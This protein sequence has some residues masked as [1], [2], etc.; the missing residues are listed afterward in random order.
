LAYAITQAV[1][2]GWWVA[3]YPGTLSYDSITY[4]WQVST[5]NWTTQHSV[6][7]NA[8]VWLSLRST[9][10]L[11]VL[12]LA[13]TLAMA[14]A[15][16]YAVVGLRRLGARAGWLILAAGAAVCLP[17]IGTF[18]VYVSKDV[19]FAVTQVFL[20]G[21]VARILAGRPRPSRRLWIALLAEFLAMGLFRQ[22]GFVVIGVTAVGIAVLFAGLRWRVL[23]AGAAGI[24]VCA[25]ANLA[26]YP[27]LGVRPVGSE[28]LFGPV[29]ADIAV[30]YADRP[31]AF[32]EADT[33]LISSVAPLE[34]WRSTANC[35]NADDTVTYGNPEFNIAAASQHQ[36]QLVDLW[37]NLGK[38]IPGEMIGTRLCRGSI[39]WNPFPGPPKGRTVKVPI[40]GVSRLFNFPPERLAQSPYRGAIQSAP[41]S[42][43][44]NRGATLLRNASAVRFFE[45]FTWRGATWCYIAY[46]TVAVLASRRR[47][48]ALLALAAVIAANQINVLINNPGQLVRYMMAPIILG[49]LL[50]PLLPAALSR[51]PRRSRA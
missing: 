10:Q 22:N 34:Y 30:A 37:L 24:V 4:V 2:L 18:T 26:V 44:V 48:L 21:T 15:L 14:A 32:T 39:A 47:D 23:A 49:I 20:L 8:L 25:I 46:L 1:L 45:W 29:Y 3:F 31:T 41:P 13:Q 5:S 6:L 50:L 27:A 28:L 19:P 12:T 40:S 38:R 43:L 33:R 42:H 11:A 7:Y 17:A 36:A 9:G 16:A 51:P 35:Y